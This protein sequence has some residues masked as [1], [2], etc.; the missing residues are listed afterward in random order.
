MIY[1]RSLDSPSTT[2][3]VT[4]KK[5]KL[6]R[7]RRAAVGWRGYQT[8]RWLDISRPRQLLCAKHQFI[9]FKT[10]GHKLSPVAYFHNLICALHRDLCKRAR[11]SRHPCSGTSETGY[12]NW[13][14]WFIY[15][16][17]MENWSDV[18]AVRVFHYPKV[19]HGGVN[20]HYGDGR[21]IRRPS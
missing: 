20:R 15:D 18:T 10:Q 3:G 13:L 8:S 4:S 17:G 9:T 19:S 14:V 2:E 5:R 16:R 7:V 21:C 6:L 11:S 12:P 1:Y